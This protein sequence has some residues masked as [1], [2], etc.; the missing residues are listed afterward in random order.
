M[1]NFFQLCETKRISNGTI[2]FKFVDSRKVCPRRK[3][4]TK[5]MTATINSQKLALLK[6]IYI[7]NSLNESFKDQ[8]TG[9]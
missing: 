9:E 7:K 3:I 8:D 4:S 5:K 6:S 2:K 1:I